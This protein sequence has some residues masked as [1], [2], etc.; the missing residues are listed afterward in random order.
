MYWAIVESVADERALSGMMRH[1]QTSDAKV[2]AVRKPQFILILLLVAA[3]A[4]IANY[5]IYAPTTDRPETAAASTSTDFSSGEDQDADSEQVESRITESP[6]VQPSMAVAEENTVVAKARQTTVSQGQ[7]EYKV[8]QFDAPEQLQVAVYQGLNE[9]QTKYSAYLDDMRC[10]SGDC[11]I[12]IRIVTHSGLSSAAA[13]MMT[14]INKRL[15]ENVLTADV[16][17]GLRLVQNLENGAGRIELVTMP[18]PQKDAEAAR[19]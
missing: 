14:R 4:I 5:V 1:K 8:G 3:G 17:M 11:E 6:S 2:V 13:D 7:S 18:R 10:E 12:L 9:E 16:I 15:E 19:R